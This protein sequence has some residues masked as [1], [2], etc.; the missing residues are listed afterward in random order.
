MISEIEPSRASKSVLAENRNR[1]DSG[2]W[3]PSLE[4]L[5]IHHNK[6]NKDQIESK[7]NASG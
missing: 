4:T 3:Y 1:T 7:L 5:E 6:A 2:A